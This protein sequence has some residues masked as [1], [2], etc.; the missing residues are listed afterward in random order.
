MDNNKVIIA[1]VIILVVM[2]LAGLFILNPTHAKTDS[3]VIV[4]SNS[5]LH[6]GDNFVIKLTDINNTPIANQIVNITIIDATG[7]ENHQQVTTDSNGDGIL[8]LNG[9]ATTNYTVKI[10]YGGNDNFTSCNTTQKLQ[11]IE[12]VEHTNNDT[13]QQQSNNQQSND[14]EAIAKAN[15]FNSYD[16]YQAAQKAGASAES[17][18][19]HQQRMAYLEEHAGETQIERGEISV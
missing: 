19:A 2:S 18:Y 5:T 9:L 1:L 14:N 12:K 7:G 4:T 3:R 13:A 16:D 8:P 15:G 10:E 17:Y 6:D 11:I